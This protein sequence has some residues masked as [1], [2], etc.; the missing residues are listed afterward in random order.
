[1]TIDGLKLPKDISIKAEKQNFDTSKR[2]VSGRLITKL[3]PVEKWKVTVSFENLTL[4][5]PF[6]TA[7]YE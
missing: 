5:L 6:Q 3:A 1:M 2:T 7:F 4:R